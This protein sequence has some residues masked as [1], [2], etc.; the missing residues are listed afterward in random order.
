M[1]MNTFEQAIFE[2]IAVAL[3]TIARNQNKTTA[4]KIR[5]ELTGK[6]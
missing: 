3:E 4:Q 2:R 6:R 1:Q 5:E